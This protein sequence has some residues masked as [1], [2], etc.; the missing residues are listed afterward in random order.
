MSTRFGS[1]AVLPLLVE[2]RAV[3]SLTPAWPNAQ[4]D[5]AFSEADRALTAA[6]A[7]QCAVSVGRVRPD[8]T[9]QAARAEVE[10]AA[11]SLRGTEARLRFAMIVAEL[12]AWDLDLATGSSCRSRQHDRVFGS[13]AISRDLARG[14]GGDLVV[15][16]TPALGGVFTLTLARA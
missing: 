4:P 10:S 1:W 15:E 14:M 7:H 2:G 13:L 12:G 3:G 16:S 9:E 11:T 5:G 6:L 8:A